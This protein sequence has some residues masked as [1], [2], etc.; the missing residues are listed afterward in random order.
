MTTQ[1]IHNSD[2]IICHV[3]LVCVTC[4]ECGC[5]ISIQ[6]TAELLHREKKQREQRAGMLTGLELQA[7]ADVVYHYYDTE[8]THYQEYEEPVQHIYSSLRLLDRMLER[9]GLCPLH[10][11]PDGTPFLRGADICP[12]CETHTMDT[13][14]EEREELCRH[15]IEACRNS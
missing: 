15:C 12:M 6:Q 4:D 11:A 8:L 5:G 7:L 13:P 14:E 3:C 9:M 2:H 1:E 10:N